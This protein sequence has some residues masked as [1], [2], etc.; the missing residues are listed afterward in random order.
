M[1]RMKLF[2]K[3]IGYSYGLIYRSSRLM[4]LIYFLLSLVC[5]SVPLAD[6]YVLKYL[7]D[8][9][10]LGQPGIRTIALCVTI[11]V[12]LQVLLQISRSATDI[13]YNSIHSRASYWYEADLSEK[14]TELPMS[15]I[16]TSEGKDIVEDVR[17]TKDTAVYTAFQMVSIASYL[18]AF[19][20]A[21][22]TLALYNAWFSCLFIALTIPGI[23]TDV[24]FSKRSEDLRRRSAPD[25]R[26]FCYYRWMLTD[27]WPA[28][29]VRMYDLT[30][31]IKGRYDTE[32]D[33]YR[34][35][36]KT[37]D[38]KK[39]WASLLA[40]AIARSGEIIFTV[41]VI[42]QAME[43]R[44]TVGDVVLYIG[45]ALSV[46][47]SFS[48][49]ALIL[50][51]G[52]VITTGM[53]GRLF[54]FYHMES[55]HAPKEK[56]KLGRFESLAFDHVCFKYPATDSYVLTGVS[57]TLNRGDK[58]SIV[59]TNGSGK[60]TV[61]KLM[62]GLYEAESG[63]ILI[64]G[65][66]MS[67]Y[68]IRDVRGLF[69]VLFQNFVQYPLTLRDSIALS[70]YGRARDDGDIIRA[71]RQSGLYDEIQM[72]LK[73]GLDSHM[74][75]QFDDEGTELSKGQWQK[76][77]LSRTYFRDA[78]IVIFDEPSAALD[79]E[80][81]DRIFKNFEAASDDRTGVMISHRISAARM[82]N[83]IIVLDGGRI[84]EQ[85]NHDELVALGGLYA[86]L[87]IRQKDKYTVT[88]A[89]QD[90]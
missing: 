9:L 5:A 66:P 16:D 46:H 62:L 81:E 48:E 69:T 15:F 42:L 55:P 17:N 34:Q 31:P 12:F 30:E 11:Y 68:D 47:H 43:G 74:S 61:I 4:I 60:T 41:L 90:E 86:E 20:V 24:F 14:L 44:L 80:A 32:K 75:R 27:A 79:A 57:F 1:N 26:K 45:F 52:Y 36:N 87:Y 64:N 58:L 67:D 10:T 82:S 2:F 56:R 35:A 29:D 50:A 70:E 33:A 84:S 40:E 25:L 23:V 78:P 49:M 53:M 59:G 39:L 88:E 89:E 76:L 77:A 83:K 7:L 63:Q 54:D 72:K 8:R 71:L 51:G 38:I 85:G 3:S 18:Y 13:L 28:K 73:D 22:M 21:F 6:T 37:L 65:Y 19:C